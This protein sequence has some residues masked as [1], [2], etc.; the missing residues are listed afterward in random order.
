MQHKRSIST[1]HGITCWTFVSQKIR[2]RSYL[3]LQEHQMT[4]QQVHHAHVPQLIM[5]QTV[6]KMAISIAF[7]RP[8]V[9]PSV[10][11]IVNNSRTQRP[12]VPKFGREGSTP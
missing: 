7:V 10:A 6:G 12:N 9:C 2:S 8:S 5:S 4:S 11:Y 1:K 3:L